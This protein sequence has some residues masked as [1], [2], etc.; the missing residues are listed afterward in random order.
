MDVCY[1]FD[2]LFQCIKFRCAKEFAQSDFQAVAQLFDCDRSGILAL[3]VEDAFDCC[4]RHGR[5]LAQLID[6]NAP[7]LTQFP[8][9][10]SNCFTSIHAYFLRMTYH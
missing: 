10:I 7:F 4:L 5:D 8:Y 3:A 6:S 2:F 9:P 1:L